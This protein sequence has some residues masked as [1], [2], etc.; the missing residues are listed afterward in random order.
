M[1][2]PTPSSILLAFASVAVLAGRWSRVKDNAYWFAAVLVV[3]ILAAAGVV[4]A[5]LTSTISEDLLRR[6]SVW[7]NDPL[8]ACEQ[9][10]ILFVGLLTALSMIDIQER[11]RP[12]IASCGYILFAL[13]GL[14]LVAQANDLISLGL[15]LEIIRL[16]VGALASGRDCSHP[17]TSRSSMIGSSDSTVYWMEWLASGLVWLGVALLANSTASTQFD[18]IEA[19]LTA[20]YESPA[21][22]ITTAVPSR[23]IRLAAGMIVL[24]LLAQFGIAP[25]QALFRSVRTRTDWRA[26]FVLLTGPLTGSIALTRLLGTVFVGLGQAIAILILTVSLATLALS[27]VLA[28]RSM[29]SGVKS[30]PTIMSSLMLLQVCW[31]AV[32]L[33][34]VSIELAHSPS[35][36][37]AF[38]TQL[39]SLALIIFSQLSFVLI[40]GSLIAGF[41][42]LGRLD[43]DVEFLEDLKGLSQYSPWMSILLSVGLLSAVGG[44]LTIGFWSHWWMMIA[45]CNVHVRSSV[46]EFSPHGGVRFLVL[47]SVLTTA[48]VGVAVVRIAREMFLESPLAQPNAVGGRGVFMT[49]VIASTVCL[50]LGLFPQAVIRPLSI[51][52]ASR[53]QPVPTNRRGSG[54][55]SIGS[56]VRKPAHSNED[57]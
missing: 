51:V 44:P 2:T 17:P 16:A 38:S 40:V 43:R 55:N 56:H 48:V 49:S 15:A 24:G 35:R 6:Q 13:A 33:M 22:S 8:A 32:G 39:D 23:Q 53:L 7:I 29:S 20:T 1:P 5:P 26:T 30:I 18:A 42:Y 10:L 9:W 12:S 27:A 31:L 28:L 50:L 36:W 14:M 45:G 34:T 46:S 3:L 57:F 19:V 37:G 54:N 41:A 4:M 21:D 52:R 47:M 11:E 25:Y